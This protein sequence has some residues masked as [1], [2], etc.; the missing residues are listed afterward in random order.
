MPTETLQPAV[1]QKGSATQT[2]SPSPD[3]APK[4][5]DFPEAFGEIEE[6]ERNQAGEKPR[7]TPP[8]PKAD[9]K[10]AP[11]AAP[12]PQVKPPGSEEPPKADPDDETATET[13]D[14]P[15]KPKDKAEVKEKSLPGDDEPDPSAKF[16]LAHDLRKEYRKLHKTVS[17]KDREIAELRARSEKAPV[18]NA[19]LEENKALK[20]RME[21]LE[22]EI[23]YVDFTKSSEF[24]EKFERPYQD[25]YTDAVEE[26]KE[27]RVNLPDGQS[28]PATAQDLDKIL[29][30][31]TQDV[32]TLANEM[33]GDAAPDVLAAR[34]R[35]AELTRNA[36]RESK[37]YRESAAERERQK[38]IKAAEEKE[39]MGRMWKQ[40][41]E[42]IA[43]RYPEHFGHIE[44][45]DEYNKEL[46]AGY[47]TVE[48]AHSPDLPMEER[49]SRLAAVRH[50]AAAFR[51]KM[52]QV[53]RLKS[54]VQELEQVVAEYEKSAPAGGHGKGEAERA[55]GAEG[56]DRFEDAGSE[57]DRLA[58][59]DKQ[60]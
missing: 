55:E 47:Q 36:N 24:K 5:G 38:A 17:E 48:K 30:A 2:A 37:R 33:F 20:K 54:R 14:D 57:I 25:A 39:G 49:M 10:P 9:P 1:Q 56:G 8:K 35:L 23:R 21:A 15:P 26:V 12:K 16:Q 60:E 4:K 51:A 28:R 27:L 50:R 44:G 18:N 13:G 43:E 41:N 40:A 31:E 42:A 45:D 32:R 7:S 29:Q 52:L 34:R 58:A 3:L 46:D 19:V 59:M 6:L 11:K 53:K 22:E